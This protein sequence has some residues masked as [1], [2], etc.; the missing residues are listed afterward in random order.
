MKLG[1]RFVEGKLLVLQ[2]VVILGFA[3]LALWIWYQNTYLYRLATSKPYHYTGIGFALLFILVAEAYNLVF[4][5]SQVLLLYRRRKGKRGW[6]G[7]TWVVFL[8]STLSIWLAVS[9][10]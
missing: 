3:G 4:V 6:P 1:W 8:L 5:L 2:L 7:T 9:A 10:A